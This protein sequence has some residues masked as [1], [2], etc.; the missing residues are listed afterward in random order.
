MEVASTIHEFMNVSLFL[1]LEVFQV[2]RRVHNTTYMI[3]PLTQ[4]L[5]MCIYIYYAIYYTTYIYIL[6]HMYLYLLLYASE[7]MKFED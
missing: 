4:L 3:Y 5:T 1:H 6:I 7:L 2:G